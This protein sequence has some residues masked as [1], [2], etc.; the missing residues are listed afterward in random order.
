M[1][2]LIGT[3]A[4]EVGLFTGILPPLQRLGRTR[5]GSRGVV[6]PLVRALTR[7]IYA[8]LRLPVS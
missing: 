3:T 5:W 7:R 6:E 4:R 1:D 2:L 8:N